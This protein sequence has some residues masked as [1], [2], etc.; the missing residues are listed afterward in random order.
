MNMKH[1]FISVIGIVGIALSGCTSNEEWVEPVGQSDA[2]IRFAANA[3]HTRG[4]D[5]TTNNLT[6]FNV[7]AYT[8]SGS[9]GT[10]Q[11][12][13]QDVEVSKTGSNLWTYSPV[14]YWPAD[15][16]VDFYAYAPA[17]WLGS[18]TP[19]EPVA[20]DSYPGD[21]DII[22]AVNPGLRGN[23]DMANAQVLMNFRHALSKMTVKLSSTNA[24]LRVQVSNVVVNNVKTK[25]NFHFPA[26]STSGVASA[27]NVGTWTDQNS[28]TMYP[29]HMSQSKS[30]V[31]NLT[32]T[33]TD[34]S[35]SSTGMGGARYMT[36]QSL[37]WLN[38]GGQEDMYIAVMCS[39]YDVRTGQKLWPN[40]NTPSEDVVPGSTF[41]DGILKFPLATSSVKDWQPGVHYIYSLVINSNE[42]M[43]Q[44]EFGTPTVDTYV[45]VN[46]L[47]E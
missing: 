38:N 19:L 29:L 27:D 4:V 12:F 34:L 36:P 14:E 21:R 28:P 47:Y 17:G 13:M 8:I 45:E 35:G 32:T 3:D 24:E 30:D 46:T 20:Y 37:V 22:Y 31:I 25:G 10:P 40:E 5:Y 42:D 7:Y 11:L 33:P 6:S 16:S 39:I 41:G 15:E 43:G 44:I 2:E 26:A 18:A 1:S 9:S 23:S